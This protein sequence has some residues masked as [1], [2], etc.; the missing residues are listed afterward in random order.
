MFTLGDKERLSF[1]NHAKTFWQRANVGV[2]VYPQ[3]VVFIWAHK[4]LHGDEEPMYWHLYP[5]THQH[6][7]AKD[8][9]MNEWMKIYICR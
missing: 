4:R 9:W 1:N 3:K 5:Q 7:M 2:R 6:L 8:E